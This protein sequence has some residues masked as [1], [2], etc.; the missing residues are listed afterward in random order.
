MVR[1][2]AEVAVVV[3]GRVVE[4]RVGHGLL[5]GVAAQ[6]EEDEDHRRKRNDVH[7]GSAVRHFFFVFLKGV[8]VFAFHCFEY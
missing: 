1:K 7:I 8:C 4:E 6:E 3:G 2:V 5:D